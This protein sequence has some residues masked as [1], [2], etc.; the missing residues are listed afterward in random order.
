MLEQQTD[1]FFGMLTVRETLELAAD[2]EGESVSE[3]AALIQTL[4]LR[5]VQQT[6]VGD[7]THRGIS[8]GERRRLAVGCSLLGRPKLLVADEPTSGLDAHQAARIVKLLK[9]ACASRHIPAVATLHQPRSSI[10]ADLDDVLLLAPRG[11]I[12]Y[13]GAA[14]GALDYF[15]RL[16]L[17]CP[18]HTNPAE[19]LRDADER[20]RVPVRDPG[21]GAAVGW[22][23]ACASWSRPHVTYT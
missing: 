7:A 9:A 1:A 20:C 17:R 4:G 19:F 23:A 16:G 3:V 8:G 21:V 13:H 6:R 14:D 18:P 5:G 10:W 11:R 12:V 2:L 22:M 15:A